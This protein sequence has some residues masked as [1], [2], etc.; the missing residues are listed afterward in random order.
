MVSKLNILFSR[1]KVK[2]LPREDL[3]EKFMEIQ[4]DFFK[5]NQ[6]IKE[7]QKTQEA[8]KKAHQ[9]TSKQPEWDKYGNLISITHR[10]KKNG[11][12]R[13]GSGNKK[14]DLIPT[15]ENTTPLDFCPDCK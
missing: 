14:K 1:N 9:P 8:N 10:K 3:E 15:E 7:S 2:E 4:E 6:E 13:K 5:K 11:G 12:R